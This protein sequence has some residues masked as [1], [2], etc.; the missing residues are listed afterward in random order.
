[1]ALEEAGVQSVAVHTHVFARLARAT[2]LANGM[3]KTRQAFVPQPVVPYRRQDQGGG[4]RRIVF[5]FRDDEVIAVDEISE[6]RRS[7]ALLE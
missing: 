5:L 4:A 2:A 6:L 1:M 7:R 3:P